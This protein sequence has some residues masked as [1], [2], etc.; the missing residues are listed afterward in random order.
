M[1]DYF[2]R[3][4]DDNGRFVCW[5]SIAEISTGDL[6]DL[7]GRRHG[8]GSVTAAYNETAVENVFGRINIELQARA[9]GLATQ[10]SA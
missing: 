10:G 5:K 6:N 8:N 3:V 4:M 9:L 2:I 7:A 1:R